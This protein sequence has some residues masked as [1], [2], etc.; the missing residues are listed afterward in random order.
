MPFSCSPCHYSVWLFVLFCFV[1][2]T[3]LHIV[4]YAGPCSTPV[5]RYFPLVCHLPFHIAHDTLGKWPASG[6]GHTCSPIHCS[7]FGSL[8]PW[9]Y[10]RMTGVL[11]KIQREGLALKRKEIALLRLDY[12][13]Y[14]C[15]WWR[16]LQALPLIGLFLCSQGKVRQN[17]SREA[18]QHLARVSQDVV[19]VGWVLHRVIAD[20]P[21]TRYSAKCLDEF[22]PG[23]C[24]WGASAPETGTEVV[25][26]LVMITETLQCIECLLCAR[27]CA[28]HFPCIFNLSQLPTAVSFVYQTRKLRLRD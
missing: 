6:V 19:D 7:L 24:P 8:V 9:C 28:E 14:F 27:H 10:R 15:W 5:L 12:F 26:T 11:E 18:A 20:F 16:P 25:I 13:R 2:N 23:F 3:S 21:R 4:T 17:L 22:R 1:S